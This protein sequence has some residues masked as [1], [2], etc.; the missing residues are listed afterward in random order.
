MHGSALSLIY[1]NCVVVVNSVCNL[2]GSQGI[3]VIGQIIFLFVCEDVLRL[4]LLFESVYWVKQIDLP[5]VGG[6]HPIC[7]GPE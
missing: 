3:Q 7:W 5:K 6:N 2:P 1:I 4:K